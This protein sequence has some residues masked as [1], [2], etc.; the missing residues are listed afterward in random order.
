MSI[1]ALFEHGR[2]LL[3]PVSPSDMDWLYALETHPEIISRFRLLG[4]TPSPIEYQQLL[5][6]N[7]LCQFMVVERTS[8]LN[9]GLVFV[10]NAD[11][12]NGH[13]SIALVA[14]PSFHDTAIVT[15]GATLLIDYVFRTWNFRKLYGDSFEFSYE[16]F[17]DARPDRIDSTGLWTVEGAYRD[18]YY[19]DGRYWDKYIV[20][21]ERSAWER[22]RE[23]LLADLTLRA[24]EE[25]GM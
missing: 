4:R 11:P 24:H 5:W 16:R 23:E 13:A 22:L 8:R 2:V 10:Y 25:A 9:A 17:G 15:E 21:I 6:A 1:G 19:S 12:F 20:S 7:V 18:F 3:R 14:H